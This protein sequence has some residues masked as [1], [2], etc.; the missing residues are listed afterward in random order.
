[1]ETSQLRLTPSPSGTATRLP[2]SMCQRTVRGDTPS[3]LAACWG[4]RPSRKALL[5][6]G[7]YP[8]R[9]R[10]PPAQPHGHTTPPD[11]CTQAPLGKAWAWA[12]SSSN[13]GSV[14]NAA[15]EG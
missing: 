6:R 2:C 8:H 13:E 9:Y 5:S 10:V 15:T 1:M 14:I 7:Y 4:S 3:V 11:T 12:P